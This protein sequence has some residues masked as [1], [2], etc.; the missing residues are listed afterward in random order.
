LAIGFLLGFKQMLVQRKTG[1]ILGPA[2]NLD[3]PEDQTITNAVRIG[4]RLFGGGWQHYL[5]VRDLTSG[6]ETV[7]PLPR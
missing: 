7:W 4:N 5:H 6:Q 3:L 2:F 1:S